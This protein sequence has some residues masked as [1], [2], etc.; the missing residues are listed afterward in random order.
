MTAKNVLIYLCAKPAADAIAFYKTAFGAVEKGARILSPDGTIGH[1][2]FTIGETTIMISD[3]YPPMEV[4]SPTTL[5]GSPVMLTI[6]VEDADAAMERAVAA[7]AKVTRP[8]ADQ[9][10]GE[11]NGQ[12]VDPFGYRWSVSQHIEDVSPEEMQRRAQA[13]YD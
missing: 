2:E 7:G 9:F 13:L 8:V 11:R 1:A 5:G 3:E 6:S 4:F 10:Y 12:I